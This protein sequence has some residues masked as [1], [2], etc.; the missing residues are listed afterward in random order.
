[1]AGEFTLQAHLQLLNLTATELAH[2]Q[3][4]GFRQ[5]EMGLEALHDLSTEPWNIHGAAGRQPQQHITNLF[6]DIDRH[7]FLGLFRR[8]SEMRGQDKSSFNGAQRG[9]LSQRFRGKYIQTGPSDHPGFNRFRDRRLINNSTA[10]T[11]H[12]PCRTFHRAQ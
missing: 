6:S 5:L 1:M 3:T 7:I 9:V 8:C 4:E 10:R 11:I 2:Q 12:N